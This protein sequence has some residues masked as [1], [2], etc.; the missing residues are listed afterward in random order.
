MT[1]TQSWGGKRKMETFPPVVTVKMFK[2]FDLLHMLDVSLGNYM[3]LT[4][5]IKNMKKRHFRLSLLEA[6][7]YRRLFYFTKDSFFQ[8]ILTLFFIA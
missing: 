2:E 4:F 6:P 8:K 3:L 5:K 7:N 1:S